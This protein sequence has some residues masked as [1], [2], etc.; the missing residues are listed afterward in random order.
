MNLSP[1]KKR[2]CNEKDLYIAKKLRER[3]IQIGLKQREVAAALGIAAQQIFK[4]EKG[5]DRIPASRLGEFSKILIVPLTYFFEETEGEICA[6][7]L[8]GLTLTGTHLS[9][10][11]V[12]LKFLLL[13]AILTDSKTQ[14]DYQLEIC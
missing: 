3:R 4:Y 2:T 14:E 13:K 8:K 10:R 5:I 9:S 6:T 12:R 1:L 7:C 11:K